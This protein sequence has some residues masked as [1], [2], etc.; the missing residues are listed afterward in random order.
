MEILLIA[1][2]FL[3]VFALE[4]AFTAAIAQWAIIPIVSAV[5]GPDL[6]FWPVFL[7]LWFVTVLFSLRKS[8]DRS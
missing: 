4:F 1:L 2:A 7:T 3:G 8:G 5:G 6:P